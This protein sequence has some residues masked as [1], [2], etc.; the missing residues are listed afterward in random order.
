MIARKSNPGLKDV[1]HSRV[2][3]AS[4]HRVNDA[5]CLLRGPTQ[6]LWLETYP[7]PTDPNLLTYQSPK[8]WTL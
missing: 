6:W 7:D 3:L 5:S 8:P 4:I 2:M 1:E